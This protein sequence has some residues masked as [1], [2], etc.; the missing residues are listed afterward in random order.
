MINPDCT[1]EIPCWQ[2]HGPHQGFQ[3]TKWVLDLSLFLFQARVK[4]LPNI[5]S[6]EEMAKVLD[7]GR[8]YNSLLNTRWRDINREPFTFV[9]YDD[10]T[11]ISNQLTLSDREQAFDLLTTLGLR[12]KP[13]QIKR[14]L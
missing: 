10:Q 1:A 14:R 8:L 5:P 6:Y 12:T 13:I 2:H 7:A 11:T 3:I 9:P 4:A